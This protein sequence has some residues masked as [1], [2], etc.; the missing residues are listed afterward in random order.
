MSQEER[1]RKRRLAKV[2]GLVGLVAFAVTG[3]STDEVLRF[4][5]PVGVT[6]Q[7]DDMRRLWTG[8]VIASLVVGVITWVLILWP[9][10]FHRKKSDKLPRQTQYNNALELIYTGV[11]V[12][13]VVVLFVF[14]ASTENKVLAE[15]DKPDVKVEALAFQWNWD[16]SYKEVGGSKPTAPGGGEIHTVGSSREIPLLVLPAGRTIEYQLRSRDVIHSFY[17]PE[18]H[19]K[20][21]VFPYPEKNNQDNTFQ[22][23]IA[24]PGSFVGRCAELCGSYHAFMNFEVRALPGEQFDQFLRL[25]GQVNP[26]TGVAY[27]TSEALTQMNC[28]QLC[29]P[30][31]TTTSPPNTDRT[32]RTASG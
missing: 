24:R 5:W 31:A 13:I 9:V 19:F 16:F 26:S 15:T 2:I 10:A 27:S 28:G 3:C 8:S 7:A 17:V 25:R 11:P 4:G 6:E 14:T 18:M 22:N 20:R 21:D 29:A 32:A 30:Y 23:K 12:I 1:S